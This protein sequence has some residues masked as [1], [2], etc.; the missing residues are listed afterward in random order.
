M[1]L[2]VHKVIKEYKVKLVLQVLEV[3]KV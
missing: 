1:E 3:H 2:R